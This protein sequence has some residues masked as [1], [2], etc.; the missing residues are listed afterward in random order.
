MRAVHTEVISAYST[1]KQENA[2]EIILRD[3]DP[4]AAD[5]M[6]RH[7]YNFWLQP[8]PLLLDA[9]KSIFFCDVVVVSEKYRLPG[10]AKEAVEGLSTLVA[11]LDP[12]FTVQ[13][14]EMITDR[15]GSYSLLDE[16]AD[17]L[18]KKHLD[19][20][21]AV[22]EFMKWLTTRPNLLQSLL[23]DAAKFKGATMVRRYRCAL[24]T[25]QIITE[26]Q[27]QPVCC[28]NMTKYLGLAYHE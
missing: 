1:T 11:G 27:S 12:N 6:L 19:K 26:A 25:K 7:L 14:L 15:Y 18:A 13:S 3:D 21:T 5:A 28:K 20:L 23:Q 24:C 2:G 17:N 8:S 10:L 22:P 4:D 9:G 16:C